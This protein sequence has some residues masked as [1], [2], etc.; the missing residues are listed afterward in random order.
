MFKFKIGDLIRH[1]DIKDR[2]NKVVSHRVSDKLISG[3]CYKLVQR[4]S[5]GRF[6]YPTHYYKIEIENDFE[7]MENKRAPHPLTNIFKDVQV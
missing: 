2:V 4:L 1:K 5:K 6:S 3:D 7:L